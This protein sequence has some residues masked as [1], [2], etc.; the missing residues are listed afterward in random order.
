MPRWIPWGAGGLVVV[1]AGVFGAVALPRRLRARRWRK[2]QA[3]EPGDGPAEAIPMPSREAATRDLVRRKC[4]CGA[5]LSAPD[6][7]SAWGGIR[8]GDRI[9]T[10]AASRCSCGV[11]TKRYYVI[12][13]T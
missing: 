7:E 3:R 12:A 9:I 10:L 8:L 1:V 4:I 6:A 2:H 11:V 5:P 13:G